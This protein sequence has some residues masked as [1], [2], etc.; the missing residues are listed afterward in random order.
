MAVTIT[1]SQ[2]VVATAVI[3]KRRVV[4]LLSDWFIIVFS[5]KTFALDP[6]SATKLLGH[7]GAAVQPNPCP[8][9]RVVNPCSKIR[10]RF[11]VGIPTP[12]S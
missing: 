10:V 7:Q 3:A 11:S 9:L 2:T 6:Q 8:S 4:V 5:R 1:T 12:L